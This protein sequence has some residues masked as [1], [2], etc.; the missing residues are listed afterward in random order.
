M[1]SGQDH[2]FL[3]QF[4]FLC[5]YITGG[6]SLSPFFSKSSKEEEKVHYTPKKHLRAFEASTQF[7][8]SGRFIC[9]FD[10]MIV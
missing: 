8:V 2:P 7:L 3:F 5:A 6:L 9:C 1:V 10:M 4:F